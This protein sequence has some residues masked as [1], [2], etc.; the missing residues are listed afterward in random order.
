MC[1]SA[2]AGLVLL[3]A[4]MIEKSIPE[5]MANTIAL[6]RGPRMVVEYHSIGGLSPYIAA[7]SLP[8]TTW[9]CG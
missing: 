9:K 3:D 7:H 5:E 1:P 4:D 6:I 8:Q 2:T